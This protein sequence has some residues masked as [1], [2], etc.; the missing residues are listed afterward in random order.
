MLIL[1]GFTGVTLVN[2]MLQVSCI[3]F[4]NTPSDYCIVCSLS[5]GTS[6]SVTVFP[7]FPFSTSPT[8]FLSCNHHRIVCVHEPLFLSFAQC[9]RPSHPAPVPSPLAVAGLLSVSPGQF[10][11]FIGVHIW[12][13]LL[14]SSATYNVKQILYKAAGIVYITKK[15]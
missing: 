7:L 12:D 6:P 14:M 9:L 13:V 2:R 11:W 5:K 15:P 3:Q 1:M 10:I 8:P 4:C